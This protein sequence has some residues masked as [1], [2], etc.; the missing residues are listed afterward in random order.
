MNGTIRQKRPVHIRNLTNSVNLYL[1][2]KPLPPSSQ[3]K[4]LLVTLKYYDRNLKTLSLIDD[5]FV[6]PSTLASELTKQV[7]LYLGFSSDQKLKMIEYIKPDK[8]KPVR[9]NLTM[10][11][12]KIRSGD[13]FVFELESSSSCHGQSIV[14]CY[15]DFLSDHKKE[16]GLDDLKL[17]VNSHFAHFLNSPEY[18]DVCFRVQDRLF[19]AHRIVLSRYP[20]FKTMFSA[21]MRESCPRKPGEEEGMGSTETS[22]AQVVVDLTESADHFLAVL[23]FIYT[24]RLLLNEPPSN[25]SLPSSPSYSRSFQTSHLMEIYAIAHKMM[26]HELIGCCQKGLADNV[27]TE[28]LFE[29]IAFADQYSDQTLLD[30]LEKLFVDNYE[31]IVTNR[32]EEYHAF[33]TSRRS[34]FEWLSSVIGS[35]FKKMKRK[36]RR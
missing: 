21:G 11:E 4:P 16:S 14:E 34:L 6:Y 20:Y 10:T 3:T 1:C 33:A 23:R 35:H 32:M 9:S 27:D 26:L 12:A 17:L 5:W 15:T 36:P 13:L 7:T 18:S 29:A 19:H 24:G 28:T 25:S 8:V 22:S 30:S 31:D 2:E